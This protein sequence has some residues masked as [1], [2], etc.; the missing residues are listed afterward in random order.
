MYKDKEKRRAAWRRY[1]HRNKERINKTRLSTRTASHYRQSYG[2]TIDD[3]QALGTHCAICGV[4]DNLCVDHEHA[5]KKSSWQA[6]QKMQYGS[7]SI[8]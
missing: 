6:L 3:V 8:Q 2:L 5:S 1:Y 7:W 4:Q